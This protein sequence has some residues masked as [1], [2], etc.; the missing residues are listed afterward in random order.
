MKFAKGAKDVR[1][2]VI[3]HGLFPKR[4]STS[5]TEKS[6]A[7]WIHNIKKRFAGSRSP[8]LDQE[9][10]SSLDQIPGWTW[11]RWERSPNTGTRKGK[12]GWEAK[13]QVIG[14]TTWGNG[15]GLGK[16]SLW[17]ILGFSAE[18]WRMGSTMGNLHSEGGPSLQA[19]LYRDLVRGR[20]GSS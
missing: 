1:K 10:I 16:A 9:Q 3:D 4:T 17:K 7:L 12:N 13:I 11:S 19:P 20:H 15:G 14:P 6:L 2:F 5:Q 18:K 8:A